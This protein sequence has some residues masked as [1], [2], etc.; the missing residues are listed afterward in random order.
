MLKIKFL[1]EGK[2]TLAI[3]ESEDMTWI[4]SI[5]LIGQLLKQHG[6]R[7]MTGSNGVWVKS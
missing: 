6:Y 5:A 4:G 1:R 3:A 7:Y 2:Q